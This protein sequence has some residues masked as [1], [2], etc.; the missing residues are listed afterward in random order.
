MS[1]NTTRFKCDNCGTKREL[2]HEGIDGSL[3]PECGI[4]RM[5]EM[6]TAECRDCDS[7]QFK[8]FQRAPG[9]SITG[10]QATAQ[11]VACG[12]TANLD[13]DGLWWS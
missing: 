12:A 7:T 6:D 4:E 11:C 2:D 8:I 10:A 5:T 3:C 1:D 9:E 13:E